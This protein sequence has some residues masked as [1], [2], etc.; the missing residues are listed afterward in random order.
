MLTLFGG[1]G[2][3]WEMPWG[4]CA[5]RTLGSQEGHSCGLAPEDRLRLL[6]TSSEG[7]TMLSSGH[8]SLERGSRPCL[9]PRH[10]TLS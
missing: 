5:E 6:L 1:S 2:D 9:L 10:P 4:W 8:K 3:V 7:A